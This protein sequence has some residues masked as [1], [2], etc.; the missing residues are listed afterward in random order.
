MPEKISANSSYPQIS[1]KDLL[2]VKS[3]QKIQDNFSNVTEVGL[4]TLDSKGNAI[5]SPSRE[6]RLCTE[7]IKDPSVKNK[8]CGSCLPTFLGGKAIVDKNLSFSCHSRLYNFIAPI[9]VEEKVMGYAILGPV[10]LFM[11]GS[12]E[13]Y[14]KAA[15]ELD[16]ELDEF[17]SAILEIKVMSFQL[18][19]S[20]LELI[21]DVVEYNLKLVYQNIVKRKSVMMGLDSLKLSRLLNALLDVAFQ[22]TNADIG[23]IMFAEKDSDEFT[24]RASKGIPEEIVSN[25]RVRLGDGIAG[26]A[27]KERTAFLID[28][29]QKDNRIRR[30]L[31]RPYISSS[32]IMPIEVEDAVLGV[33]NLG[34]LQ[35]S[36]VR[37]NRDNLQLVNKLIGLATVALHE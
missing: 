15:E 33:M 25:T 35:T 1:L 3:W 28:N 14:L 10:I 30:Y 23:S 5:T 16:I 13:V 37:F 29:T 20:M 32:M 8:V 34:A 17:W 7:L 2:D 18:A 24:I 12:K 21:K 26:T 4:R 9:K 6:S 11:R 27:A 22:V 31:R 19:Q 36:A